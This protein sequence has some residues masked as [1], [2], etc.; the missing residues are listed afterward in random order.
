MQI[1]TAPQSQ[2]WWLTPVIPALWEA[3]VGRSPEVRSSRPAWSTWQ[4]PVSTKNTKISWTS[5]HMS[6]IPVTQEAEAGESLEPRRKR[7]QGTRSC[8]IIQAG[9]QWCGHSSL[10]PQSPGLKRSF[11]LSLKKKGS[12][13]VAQASLKF[14][15]SS[16]PPTSAYEVLGLQPGHSL[17]G[18]RPVDV[19]LSQQALRSLHGHL[20]LLL[21]QLHG[22]EKIP[23]LLQRLLHR[24]HRARELRTRQRHLLGRKGH[25]AKAYPTT[26]L[27]YFSFGG[28]GRDGV[29]SLSLLPRLKCS[30]TISAHCNLHL[31]GSRDSPASASQVAGITE[32]GFYHVGQAG[33]ELL[34]S[35]D[36]PTLD[37]Q[38]AGIMDTSHHAW[39]TLLY[40]FSQ[41]I[42]GNIR[43]ALMGSLSFLPNSL[44]QAFPSPKPQK[45][46]SPW[47]VKNWATGWARW[48]TPVS[49]HFGRPRWTDHEHV[50]VP[51]I[52]HGL[53]PSLSELQ[54]PSWHLVTQHGER[55]A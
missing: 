46:T 6:V 4:N 38:S 13:C 18:L 44:D 52:P 9:V 29:D 20:H 45:G 24:F 50:P 54:T 36:L 12:H 26:L 11:H 33:L 23:V 53:G 39:P 8:S 5:W 34:T 51:V 19:A 37:S 48:L 1:R 28:G 10:L 47:P 16:N 3:E 49:Q 31:L 43:D 32:M 17:L 14:V 15:G 30:G 42:P 25:G 21:A 2:A 40:Y 22:G 41:R 7:L 35:G 55:L 27:Y